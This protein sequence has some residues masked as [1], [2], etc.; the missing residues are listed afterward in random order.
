[1]EKNSKHKS[2][3]RFKIT[4]SICAVVLIVIF[5]SSSL[6]YF[7]TYK[8]LTE[9]IGDKYNQIAKIISFYISGL[10]SGEVTDVETYASRPLWKDAIVENNLKYEN[11]GNDAIKEHLIDMDKK[12]IE[13]EE[14]NPLLQE[15]LKNRISGSMTSILEYRQNVAELILTDKYGGIVAVS[16]K[17]SDFYQADEKWWQEAYNSGKG[18]VYV[19]NVEF[20]DSSGRWCV[21]IAVPVKD[22]NDNVIGV[23]KENM[24]VEK[25]LSFLDFINIG[26]TGHLVLTNGEGNILY[27]K[28]IGIM[29]MPYVGNENFKDLFRENEKSYAVRNVHIHKENMIAAVDD[30]YF[31][32]MPTKELPWKIF[33][34]QESSEVFYTIKKF[35]RGMFL[36]LIG[37]LAIV[38]PLAFFF[39]GFISKPIKKL[40][41]A[42]EKII[43]GDLDYRIKLETGDEI[44]QLGDS[45]NEM[46]SDIQEK[47]SQLNETKNQIEK[48]AQ[49]LE[50]KVIT[51]TEELTHV[52]EA[53]LN[54]LEDL[55]EAK[56][57]LQKA[58]N[59]KT[60]FTSMVSHE[61]RTPLTAIKEG[62]ALIAD[63]TSGPVN[64]E[65][66][67]FLDIAKRNVDRLARLINDVLD[68]QKLEAGIVSFNM[69]ENNVNDILTEVKSA[70]APLI[71]E[72]GLELVVNLCDSLPNVKCDKDKII[73]VVTNIVN[74]AI[75]FTQK[76]SI[77]IT[78]STK[79]KFP[80]MV[81]VCVKDTGPGI[82]AED[83]LQL[84]QKY[85]QFGKMTDRKGGSGLG[86]AISRDIIKAHKGEIW[87]ES[88][89][90]KGSKFYFELPI[91]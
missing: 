28:G 13:A 38:V 35:V 78:S 30:V 24:D 6:V 71:K 82:S 37:I 25:F 86:L 42:T 41:E 12:W 50:S 4:A 76:G 1:M 57:K 17:T 87:A 39:S 26:K 44:E 7:V 29:T 89:L 80:D 32:E 63:G 18:S 52:N 91:G 27:H 58:L 11:M 34:E 22:E 83:M 55:S 36:I 21:I 47:Q 54:I 79:T 59:I 16:D 75:K 51:R 10:L 61:L 31:Q 60:E 88:E 46:V 62:I 45:F 70:M 15:Y 68:F 33:V 66:K 65:Q 9:L 8:T 49:E 14:D 20:D 81:Q 74:N 84:F 90:G 56:N 19:S 23:C 72:R 3:I 77:E 2:G 53:T 5:L 69:Q 48:S 40:H 67:E 73:Q 64:P 43:L 85:T